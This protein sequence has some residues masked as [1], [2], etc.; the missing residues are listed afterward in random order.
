MGNGDVLLLIQL[1]ASD[2]RVI[3]N[4]EVVLNGYLGRAGKLGVALSREEVSG[5]VLNEYQWLCRGITMCLEFRHFGIGG[6]DS[7]NLGKNSHLR[8]WL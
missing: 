4:I 5:M 3:G 6:G 2:R 7:R 8:T 1:G